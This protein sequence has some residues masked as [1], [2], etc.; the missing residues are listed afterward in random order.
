[1]EKFAIMDLKNTPLGG[2]LNFDVTN[3]FGPEEYLI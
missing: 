1:M 2:R 3:G